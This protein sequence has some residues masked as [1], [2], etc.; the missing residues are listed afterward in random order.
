MVDIDTRTP[1]PEISPLLFGHNI[2]HTRKTVW[3]GLSAQLI[4]NRKFAGDV[5]ENGVA[6]GWIPIGLDAAVFALD[7]S[8][9]YAPRQ[10]Q[11]IVLRDKRAT[12]GL[13]QPGLA[14][15]EGV[16]YQLRLFLKVDSARDITISISSFKGR[17]IFSKRIRAISGG[18]KN[19]EYDFTAGAADKNS[20]L[21]ITYKTPG[22]LWLGAVSLLP[23][24][25]FLGMRKDVIER[26]DEMSAPYLRWPGGNFSGD[27]YWK[28]GLPP[29]DKRR[30]LK[31]HH[32]GTL[33]FSNHYDFHEINTDDFIQLCRRLGSEPSITI[34]IGHT[35]PDEAAEWV[36][37]CNGSHSTKWGRKRAGRGFKKPF[38]VKYWSVG[39]EIWGDWMPSHT[40]PENYAR[41]AAKFVRAMKR[42]DPTIIII[43]S[44]YG[45][46]KNDRAIKW[47]NRV[48]KDFGSKMDYISLHNYTR[49]MNSTTGAKSIKEFKRVVN[50]PI[51][52]ILNRLRRERR[53]IDEHGPKESPVD[54]SFDEW[55]VWAAWFRKVS[56][57][58]GIYVAVMLNMFCRESRK[59]GMDLNAYFEP[60]NEGA[61]DVGPFNARLT[62]VGQ[63]FA[64]FRAHHN[65][66]LLKLKTSYAPPDTDIAASLT[67]DGRRAVITAINKNP[68]KSTDV[69][70]RIAKTSG[71]QRI[72]A[73]LLA[74][75]GFQPGS[76]FN[77][78]RCQVRPKANGAFGIL[79]PKHSVAL[80]TVE[81]S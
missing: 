35:S 24:D 30:A 65:N 73:K 80:I 57:A 9:F 36:E 52:G 26:L 79:L 60:I 63:V 23:T 3:K 27:Y 16:S 72:K 19:Y 20:Q 69:D 47:D 58:E 67:P 28:D 61:I 78:A 5:D 43:G 40:T 15:K 68:E 75:K 31:A 6:F 49:E 13:A 2:E 66:F 18:W 41:I 14:I 71:H 77:T 7:N 76:R 56:V 50:D 64:M 34:D 45:I 48:I 11:R 81:F 62:A 17:K 37:Y 42:A 29:V 22:C 21:Q 55:N 46:M 70:F 4:A 38:R 39:N 51:K 33:Q 12:C 74:A 44:G 32:P 25:N 54:L 1:G 10:S 8:T 53:I 59:L